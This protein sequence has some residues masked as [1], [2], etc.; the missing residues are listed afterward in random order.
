MRLIYYLLPVV[1]AAPCYVRLLN[2][3]FGPASILDASGAV[4]ASPLSGAASAYVDAG[5][6]G[7]N[8][9]LATGSG[10]GAT[11]S[12][13]SL[14]V[15]APTRHFSALVTCSSACRL[16]SRG[17]TLSLLPDWEAS[18]T[19][20]E[21]VNRIDAAQL[22]VVHG[23][24]VPVHIFGVVTECFNCKLPQLTSEPLAP[25]GVWLFGGAA[26]TYP[27]N[28]SARAVDTGNQ[29][30]QAT[31]SLDEHGAY[32]LVFH[33]IGSSTLLEDVPG[34]N[35][36]LPLLYA[37]LLLAALGALHKFVGAALVAAYH[38]AAPPAPAK[39]GEVTLLG[40]WGFDR[41]LQKAAAAAAARGPRALAPLAARGAPRGA[42]RQIGG[43]SAQK[44]PRAS[45]W[46]P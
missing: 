41:V 35:A 38:G 33:G 25:G 39:K 23:L 18:F 14:P 6:C 28:F 5:P 31:F 19:D 27:Y 16:T 32:T 46:R 21:G 36:H 43:V 3:F 44:A 7:A 8:L 40:F 24:E 29:L 13:F 42:A 2:E 11:S 12:S 22:R 15:S 1:F 20:G 17:A 37:A 4:L 9:T 34:R 26:S 10:G 45:F 30:G